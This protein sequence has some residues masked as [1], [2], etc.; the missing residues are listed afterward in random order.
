MICKL[1]ILKMVKKSLEI[2]ELVIDVPPDEND[3]GGDNG[4]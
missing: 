4:S 1:N 2:S 3:Y